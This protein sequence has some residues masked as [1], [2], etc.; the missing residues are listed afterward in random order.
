MN[1]QTD[2]E[3]FM[4]PLN[5]EIALERGIEW[6]YSCLFYGIILT[7]C[8]YE[9]SKS[10]F[11][12]Q[13]KTQEDKRVLKQLKETIE[14]SKDKITE[15]E[16][17]Y[18]KKFREL[19]VEIRAVNMKMDRIL[20]ESDQTLEKEDKLNTIFGDLLLRYNEIERKLDENQTNKEGD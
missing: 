8:S 3:M 18:Q 1:I 7:V 17:K 11:N 15:I 2:A 9:I 14:K 10:Y 13:F 16:D 4:K 12:S 20:K 19:K 6:F 5:Q